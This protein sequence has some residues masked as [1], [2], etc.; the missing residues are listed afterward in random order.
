M[1]IYFISLLLEGFFFPSIF[2]STP[3]ANIE[4]VLCPNDRA[5]TLSTNISVLFHDKI[6][7]TYSA[8][9]PLLSL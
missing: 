7:E 1:P 3:A 5:F 9:Q 4:F 6:C 8:D 2:N